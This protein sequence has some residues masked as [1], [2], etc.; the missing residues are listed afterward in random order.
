MRR[1]F[2]RSEEE[3]R[4]DEA[5]VTGSQGNLHDE[6]T[7]PALTRWINIRHIPFVRCEHALGFVARCLENFVSCKDQIGLTAHCEADGS[8][9]GVT[10]QAAVQIFVSVNEITSADVGVAAIAQAVVP[11]DDV[12]RAGV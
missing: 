5:A 1:V 2:H 9:D 10:G 3:L 8:V 12:L 4:S 6:Q 7:I 11:N